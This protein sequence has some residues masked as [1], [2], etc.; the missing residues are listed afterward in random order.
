[1]KLHYTLHSPHLSETV[2][3]LHGMGSCGDDWELQLPALTPH[4]RVLAPDAR[5]HGQSPKPPGSYSIT[6][7]TG[8]VVAL[9]DE[10]KIEP[11][12]VVGL[13]MGGCMALQ[14]A[15]AHPAR[16]RTLVLVNAFAKIRPAG[17]YGVRRFF[18]RVWSLQ[19]GTME[20]VVTPVVESMFPKPDQAELRRVAIERLLNNNAKEPYQ[21]VMMA[22]T[23]FNVLRELHRI[24]CPTL[25][26]AGDRDRTVPMR[27]KYDL[28][29]G[30]PGSEFVVVEDSG[31]GTPV[32][33]PEKFNEVLL[34]FL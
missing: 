29:N 22:V 19:F 18:Q 11:V 6:Q 8:D 16:T 24:T 14:M 23:R 20:E 12:H 32:D 5:G 15:I 27:C 33:Q 4:Y 25:I 3:L 13:S 9:L 1:M 31:H 2:L 10:L 17:L 21:A 26:I 7:M 28:H 30:I 34:R